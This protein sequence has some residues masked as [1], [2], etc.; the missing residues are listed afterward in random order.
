MA[1][2]QYVLYPRPISGSGTGTVTSVGMT[3]PAFLSVSGSPIN[4]AGTLAVTL[5]GLALPI[6]NGGTNSTSALSNAKVMVSTAGAIVESATTTTEL[7]FL[8]ATSSIQTQL[9][10][11]QASGN[12]LTA[13]TG[14]VAASGPGSAAATIQ[15][16]AVTLAKM[17]NLAANSILGNN[18]GSPATPLALTVSQVN[19]L[20]GTFSNPMTTLGDTIYGGA[21]G[22]GTALSGN[23]SATKM[24]LTQ[25]GTGSVSAAPAWAALSAAD[26]VQAVS[27]GTSGN[28]LTSNGSSWIS[29]PFAAGGT[30]T[31]VG[32]TAPSFLTV[33]GSPITL[34]GTL[35]LTLATQSPNTVLI[36]PGSGGAAAPTFRVLQTADIPATL[37]TKTIQ[38]IA[39]NTNSPGSGGVTLGATDDCVF[40]TASSGPVSAGLPTA[41]GI[42]GKIYVIQKTDSTFNRVTFTTQ[43]SQTIGGAAAS[44]IN[45]NT[46]NETI[47][48]LSD[49]SNW[50]IIDWRI[51]C[52]GV[53][54]TPTFTG[55]GT[56][57]NVTFQWR[58]MGDEVEILGAFS[59]GTTT[60][61]IGAVSLPSGLTSSSAL[62]NGSNIVGWCSQSSTVA[63]VPLI[64]AQSATALNFGSGAT[65]GTTP[66]VATANFAT[67]AFISFFAR[68]PISGWNG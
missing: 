39:L 14:D 16:G 32:L 17:A 5:S 64:C 6:A 4:S 38:G 35:A 37:T 22:V 55:F 41:V 60:A 54:Y 44:T 18:T 66:Q 53:S 1:T 25:T 63:S 9:N 24:F 2:S 65:A 43:L 50:K 49:G 36:G 3:V 20:L 62:F 47:T 48:L 59:A 51:P 68:I 12:Y 45:L 27:P 15:A 42:S 40:L 19:T 29:A 61:V 34:S 26:L 58:R 30:V 28:V 11:K 52:V 21:S 13:L 7:G 23:T 46:Q 33:A 57:T 31:S 8:D 67:G 10:S 56:P